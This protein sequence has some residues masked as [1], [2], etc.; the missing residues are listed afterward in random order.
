MLSILLLIGKRRKSKTMIRRCVSIVICLCA[1]ALSGMAQTD[2]GTITGTVSDASGAVIPGAMVE[3]K[4]TS[5]GAVYQ[6]GSSETGNFTL[7]QLPVG[8]YELSAT[9]PGFKKFVRPNLNVQIAQTL[10]IDVALEVGSAGEQVTVEAAAP[11]LKT[12]SGEV[13]HVVS[14]DTLLNL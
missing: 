7:P 9:L 3:A 1:F 11:L 6:A 12:E 14:G 4:N 5:T 10:R 8:T 13:S 2:R